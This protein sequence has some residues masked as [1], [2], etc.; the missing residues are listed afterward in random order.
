MQNVNKGTLTFIERLRRVLSK[1]T[2]H[3]VEMTEMV[4][5]ELEFFQNQTIKHIDL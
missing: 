5:L 3:Q 1:A 2:S 4:L